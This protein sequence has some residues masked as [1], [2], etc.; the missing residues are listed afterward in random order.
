[1]KPLFEED[2]KVVNV[3]LAGFADNIVA[4]GGA[5]VATRVAAAR[6]GRSRGGLGARAHGRAIPRIDGGEPGRL[7]PLPRRQPALVDVAVRARSRSRTRPRG[8]A[9]SCTPGR[10]SRGPTMC[11]PMRGAVAGRHPLRRLGRHDR[12]RRAARRWRSVALEPCHH[13]GAVGPMAGIISPSMPVW[14]VE[15]ADGGNRAYCN[16]NEGLGKVL[17]FG[18]NDPGGARPAAV[19]SA[20]TSRRRCG[21]GT[22]G[23]DESS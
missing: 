2:L 13:H 3:G 6:A 17:R 14:V 23:S 18:A 9:A 11:G 7:R 8:S 20:A 10:R 16:F 19:A 4:A 12:G 21:G 1:M 15:N 5:C 22:R